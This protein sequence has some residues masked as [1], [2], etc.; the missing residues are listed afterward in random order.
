MR[1]DDLRAAARPPQWLL[2]SD[3]AIRWQVMRDLTGEAPARLQPS[4]LA[5]Q[6]KAGE[7]NFS[8][9]ISCR[10]LGRGPRVERR[11]AGGGPGL[12]ITLYTL[13]VLKDLGLDPASKQARK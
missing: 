4:G 12:L 6:P 2:D 5:S 7:P 8:P 13:V 9:P 1:L 11:F 10:Q 3:P